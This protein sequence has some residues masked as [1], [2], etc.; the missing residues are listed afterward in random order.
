MNYSG[1][2]GNIQHPLGI[3]DVGI[4]AENRQPEGASLDVEIVEKD[5]N[6]VASKLRWS[7]LSGH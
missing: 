3:L 6:S 4:I 2:R 5:G 7:K 1:E